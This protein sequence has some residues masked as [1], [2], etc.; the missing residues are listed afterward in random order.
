MLVGEEEGREGLEPK[1]LVARMTRVDDRE[2]ERIGLRGRWV[3]R[4]RH[5]HGHCMQPKVEAARLAQV[6]IQAIVLAR[7]DLVWLGHV[8]GL[9][10]VFEKVGH[11]LV[12]EK[13][14]DA[15]AG[16]PVVASVASA[17]ISRCH[18]LGGVEGALGAT[19]A[20]NVSP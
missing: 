1:T 17:Q 13:Q 20:L 18:A 11:L 19:A 10:V 7:V 3:A 6:P 4:L 16:L 9:V 5:Q 2:E 12:A 8:V 15:L 14:A